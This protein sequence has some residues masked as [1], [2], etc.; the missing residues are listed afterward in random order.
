MAADAADADADADAARA[1]Y[2]DEL[3]DH[4]D[5]SMAVGGEAG[6]AGG[7]VSCFGE[8][9]GAQIIAAPYGLTPAQFNDDSKRS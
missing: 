5:D 2:S 7:L 1:R 8:S 9:V 4:K 6:P 3:V